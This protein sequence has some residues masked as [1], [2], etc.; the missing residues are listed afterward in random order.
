MF[1]RRHNCDRRDSPTWAKRSRS[2]DRRP[3]FTI[4]ELIGTL[5]LLGVVFTVSV[6]VLLA[7]AK[8]RKNT[9]QRQHA[10]QHANSLLEHVTARNWSDLA[11]GVQEIPPASSDLQALLPGID[12]R[13][14]VS[15]PG[16]DGSKQLTVSIRW[17]NQQGQAVTPIQLVAWVYP[18]EEPQP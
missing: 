14:E 2:P 18:S 16:A 12:Q 11:V 7:V 6:S 10:L 9:V 13:F 5:I 1:L 17:K 8:E 15:E 4:V 3:A